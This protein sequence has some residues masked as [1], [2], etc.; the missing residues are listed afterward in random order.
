MADVLAFNASL[1]EGYKN[2]SFY[3]YQEAHYVFNRSLKYNAWVPNQILLPNNSLSGQFYNLSNPAWNNLADIV[4]TPATRN[5]SNA[6]PAEGQ[7]A[8][9]S[10]PAPT[11]GST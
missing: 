11:D 2:D 3:T 6:G 1:A 10:S 8:N 9:Q 7:P 5:G 4:T